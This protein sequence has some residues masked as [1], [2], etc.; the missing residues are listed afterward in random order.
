MKKQNRIIIGASFAILVFAGLIMFFGCKKGATLSLGV[1]PKASF[2]ATVESDGHTVFLVNTTSTPSMAYYAAPDI[3]LGFNDL[4]GDTASVNFTFAG[5]YTIKMLAVG[6]GGVDSASTQVTTT[7]PDPAGCDPSKPLGFIASCTQKTWK[8]N[9]AAGAFIVSQ[10]PGGNGYWWGNGTSDITGRSACFN[11][12][13]TFKYD[14]AGDFVFNDQGDWFNDGSYPGSPGGNNSDNLYT[15]KQAAW[16]SGNFNYSVSS[17][18]GI[19]KLG[20]LKVM[21]FGAHLVLQAPINGSDTAKY[22]T[23]SS[24]TYDI[25]NMKK[26]TTDATGT[27]DLLTL[28]IQYCASCGTGSYNGNSNFPAGWWTYVLRS[29]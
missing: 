27:Y 6:A 2:T 16:G 1:I 29:Y 23:A 9:P 26:D 14:R 15:A 17:G 11:D 13:Y 18:T 28:T 4:K 3:N 20:Q 7:V 24:V 19:M 21:G 12:E 22:V 10:F 5:T 8:V 25:W